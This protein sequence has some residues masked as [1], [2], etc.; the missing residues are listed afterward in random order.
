SIDIRFPV[1]INGRIISRYPRQFFI[2][3]CRPYCSY[4]EALCQGVCNESVRL[5]RIETYLTISLHISQALRT[6]PR[7]AASQDVTVSRQEPGSPPNSDEHGQR[8]R[9]P[10]IRPSR[11]AYE[12]RSPSYVDV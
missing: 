11:H 8:T 1:D 10:I 9:A 4:C 7:E 12:A 6:L 2:V 3:T 5:H